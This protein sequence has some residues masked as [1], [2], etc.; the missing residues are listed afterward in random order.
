MLFRSEPGIDAHGKFILFPA[1]VKG[2]IVASDFL[3]TSSGDFVLITEED[4]QTIDG[5]QYLKLYHN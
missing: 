3:K 1:E 2:Q 5:V 4:S